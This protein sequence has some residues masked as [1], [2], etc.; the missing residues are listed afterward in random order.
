MMAPHNISVKPARI[1]NDVWIGRGATLRAGIT[2]GTG[3]VIAAGAIV[4]KDVPPYA[5]VGGIP[6]KVIKYRFPPDLIT[7]LLATA[8]WEYPLEV[9]AD[10]SVVNPLQFC[11]EFERARPDLQCRVPTFLKA[12]DILDLQ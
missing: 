12:K 3:A 8:W 2:I 10:F 5:I 11:D 1:H 4:T 9:M 6:A 7:R